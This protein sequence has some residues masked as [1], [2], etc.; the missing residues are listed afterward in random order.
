M[1][2]VDVAVRVDAADDEL[3]VAIQLIGELVAEAAQ[4]PGAAR[5]EQDG[6]GRRGDASPIPGSPRS[7][8]A[9]AARR[10]DRS[11]AGDDERLLP[12]RRRGGDGASERQFLEP[13]ARGSQFS[14]FCGTDGG[15]GEAALSWNST[16]PSEASRFSASRIGV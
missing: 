16:S 7:V 2:G 15:H 5:F 13:A 10:S 9:E 4:R 6:G 1:L 3:A 12:G 14:E 11:V 8:F